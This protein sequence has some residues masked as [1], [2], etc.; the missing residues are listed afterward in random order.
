VRLAIT[1]ECGLLFAAFINYSKIKILWNVTL[2]TIRI[3][4]LDSLRLYHFLNMVSLILF[5]FLSFTS[6]EIGVLQ[7]STLYVYYFVLLNTSPLQHVL[8]TSLGNLNHSSSYEGEDIP[9]TGR[10]SP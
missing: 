6:V 10:G 7:V 9:V 5:Y 1:P 3:S 8:C 2:I 4:D